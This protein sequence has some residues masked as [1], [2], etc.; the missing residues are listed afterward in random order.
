MFKLQEKQKGRGM[1]MQGLKPCS[2]GVTDKANANIHDC[3]WRG[4]KLGDSEQSNRMGHEGWSQDWLTG[5]EKHIRYLW[6]SNWLH[7]SFSDICKFSMLEK[8]QMKHLF[9]RVGERGQ[10]EY[11][12]LDSHVYFVVS[13][14][15]CQEI[16]PSLLTDSLASLYTKMSNIVFFSVGIIWVEQAVSHIHAHW[17]PYIV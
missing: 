2:N 7:G 1:T 3:V 13:C 17:Y 11:F 4:N 9:K 15:I 14:Q 5:S 12:S 8:M 10:A 16:L 6:D